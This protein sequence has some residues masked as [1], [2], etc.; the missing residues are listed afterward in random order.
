LEPIVCRVPADVL[1]GEG[2][3]GTEWF[4]PKRNKTIR[5]PV[6]RVAGRWE[7]FYGGELPV[8]DGTVAELRLDLD[9]I[10]N[11]VWRDRLT[12]QHEFKV[13]DEGTTLLVGLSDRVHVKWEGL[14]PRHFPAGIPPGVSRWERIRLGP[15]KKKVRGTTRSGS[16]GSR[17]ATET[18]G[19]WLRITGI[20]RCELF[21]GMILMPEGFPVHE[22]ISLNHAF[23]LL[24]REYER[25]RISNTGNVY[26]RIFYEDEDRCWYPLD[27]LRRG[28]QA[29]VEQKLLR[30]LW[31]DIRA[32][33]GWLPIPPP[34]GR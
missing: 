1:D 5:V 25:H 34:G 27:D 20:D 6:K 15:V 22:A 2:E 17:F 28:V 7:F 16:G 19:L 32:K 8:K 23:T 12:A 11:E 31:N 14:T 18:G 30:A 26:T 29:K 24:S 33:L 10:D 13:L 3:M 4:N 9:A 21:S